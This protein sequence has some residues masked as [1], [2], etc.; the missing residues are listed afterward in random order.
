MKRADAY[1][2]R[3]RL[4]RGAFEGLNQSVSVWVSE[5]VSG[6]HLAHHP[7][8]RILTYPHTHL[9]TYCSYGVSLLMRVNQLPSA[10]RAPTFG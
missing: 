8:A 3:G 5:C 6:E 9:L 10:A 1:Q 2:K 7:H 4:V